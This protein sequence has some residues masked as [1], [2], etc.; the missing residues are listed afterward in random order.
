SSPPALL[1]L[2]VCQL[3]L[4]F[5]PVS[6]LVENNFKQALSPSIRSHAVF[7][8]CKLLPSTHGCNPVPVPVHIN[9]SSK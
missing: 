4:D 2:S 8:S 1:R 7:P 6:D 5:S 9:Y 3:W